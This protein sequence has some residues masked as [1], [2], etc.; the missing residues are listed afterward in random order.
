MPGQPGLPGHGVLAVGRVLQP[1]VIITEIQPKPL[2]PTGK[3]AKILWQDLK[4][5]ILDRGIAHHG[6]KSKYFDRLLTG[7]A[8]HTFGTMEEFRQHF[9]GETSK[10]LSAEEALA[11][12]EQSRLVPKKFRTKR[13]VRRFSMAR[14]PWPKNYRSL[15]GVESGQDIRHVVRNATLKKAIDREREALEQR[16]SSNREA[17][18]SYYNEMAKQLGVAP[19]EHYR[20]TVRAIYHKVYLHLGN[21]FAEA[22]G[23]NRAIGFSADP[24]IAYGNRLEAAGETPVAIEKVHQFVLSE[25]DKQV[26]ANLTRAEKLSAEVA[27]TFIKGLQ[28]Y[29]V[30]LHSFLNSLAELWISE[31]GFGSETDETTILAE[32][33]DLADDLVDIGDN[34]GF[35][36][37]LT[38]DKYSNLAERQKLLIKVETALQSGKYGLGKH[39]LTEILKGFLSVPVHQVKPRIPASQRAGLVFPVGRI[40]RN[41]TKKARQPVGPTAAVY[42]GAVLE[43]LTAE[44]LELAG[45]PENTGGAK[46]ITPQ[47]LHKAVKSD[48][49]LSTL[50]KSVVQ[51]QQ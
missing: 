11:A 30:N 13:T 43:Y 39:E 7:P 18:N 41:L 26:K 49:E 15:L 3:H 4:L 2:A 14:P 29:Q 47:S 36:L 28:E 35:D 10:R 45:N 21:L 50:L 51:G 33:W 20:E 17:L 40:H 5:D 38:D 46:R 23:V 34:F 6:L 31:Y 1:K 44:L 32:S 8:V 12:D 48:D 37:I 25:I 22:G 9:V 27:S 19:A 16:T 24:I 42:T